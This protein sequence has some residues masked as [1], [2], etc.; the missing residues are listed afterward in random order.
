MPEIW[1]CERIMGTY[2]IWTQNIWIPKCG[3]Q[4][5]TPNFSEAP[6][7]LKLMLVAV[8]AHTLD[9]PGGEG[10]GSRALG[11]RLAIECTLLRTQ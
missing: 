11:A 10:Q 6:I 7:C 8:Q 9:A 3:P 1:G 4:N 2:V 5:E